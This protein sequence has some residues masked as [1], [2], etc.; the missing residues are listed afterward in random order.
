MSASLPRN[1]TP[2]PATI[3]AA[4]PSLCRQTTVTEVFRPLP[5]PELNCVGPTLGLSAVS[6]KNSRFQLER[7]TFAERLRG[8]HLRWRRL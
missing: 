4:P 8:V 5:A 1:S 6:E 7:S 3:T 2:I